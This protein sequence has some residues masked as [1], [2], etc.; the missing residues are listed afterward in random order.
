[1]STIYDDA[2][3]LTLRYAPKEEWDAEKLEKTFFFRSYEE[4]RRQ[5]SGLEIDG[6]DKIIV[7]IYWIGDFIITPRLIAQE[8]VI[9]FHNARPLRALSAV[10]CEQ[11]SLSADQV[12]ECD[13]NLVRTGRVI[14]FHDGRG[15]VDVFYHPLYFK[16]EEKKIAIWRTAFCRKRVE[17]N[18]LKVKKGD[19]I[20]FHRG[21]AA[22]ILT[23]EEAGFL[24]AQTEEIITG[25]SEG[26]R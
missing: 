8:G 2:L 19:L 13:N 24:E 20:T 26:L 21:K 15:R 14:R 22:E 3:K 25:F 18:H 17:R 16:F 23:E 6:I 5:T 1:M 11:G 7:R 10:L 12:V 4:I 9:L